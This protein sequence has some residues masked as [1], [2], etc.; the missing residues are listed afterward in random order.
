VRVIIMDA[1]AV[2]SNGGIAEEQHRI[3]RN[4]QP[5]RTTR[6]LCGFRRLLLRLSGWLAIDEVLVFIHSQ[7]ACCMIL[8]LHGDEDQRAG[9]ARL[10]LDGA[11]GRDAADFVALAQ[12]V[13]ELQL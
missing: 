1:V 6:R 9:A 8:M 4:A 13:M 5:D 3:G 11:D 12:A 7:S 10:A 2:E